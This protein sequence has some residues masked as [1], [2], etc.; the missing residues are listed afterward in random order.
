[1]SSVKP[2]KTLV[3]D[4]VKVSLATHDRTARWVNE[5]LRHVDCRR[6]AGLPLDPATD[7]TKAK[8]YET[9]Y[10]A[11]F[12][13]NKIYGSESSTDTGEPYDKPS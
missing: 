13:L 12:A 6:A 2:N 4:T 9:H 5:P 8:P 1:M 3:E 10:D 11:E 7:L